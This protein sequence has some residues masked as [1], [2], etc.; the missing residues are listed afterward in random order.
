VREKLTIGLSL[1]LTGEFAPMGRDAEAALRL[2]VSDI[3]AAGGVA[4]AGVRHEL[5]LECFDD[6]S[7]RD[8]AAEIYRALCFD[9][10]IDLL[11]GPYSSALARVAAP[12]AEE[13]RMVM[14]NHG[15]ADDD[16][17]ERGYRMIVG[18]LTPASDYMAGFVNLLMT[19]KFWR[20]RLAIISAKGPFARAVAGGL[21]RDCAQPRARRRGVRVR[22]R[23][24]GAFDPDR[25]PNLVVRALR[26]NRVNALISI[27]SYAHD[28]A[29]MRLVTPAH[30]NLPVLGCVAAAV[31]RFRSDLGEAAEGIVGPSQWEQDAEIMPDLGPTPVE[32]SRRLHGAS[33]SVEGD[34]TA[35]QG[36]A[37]GLV[38]LAAVR[39]ADSLDQQRIRAAF[40]D[41]RTT[42]FYGDFAINRVTGRQVAHKMLLVQW[43]DGRKV[44]I[45]PETHTDAGELEFPSGWRLILASLRSL[46]LSRHIHQIPAEHGSEGED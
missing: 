15:G 46:R 18:V 7:R 19:L 20:K 17:Y 5:A 34:Y 12:I 11:F 24:T 14:V 39:A 36:Y 41:L 1:S 33:P 38:T 40:S 26:R 37:A 28:L 6:N 16:L 35:A 21:T 44:I 9:K 42:T 25:T 45:A 43:H 30:L 4:A 32:F 2:F 29:V 10:H 13:A 8:R 22:L 31:N 3:N 23:Y 27:G